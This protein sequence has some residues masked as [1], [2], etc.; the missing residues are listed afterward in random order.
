[1]NGKQDFSKPD[2][3]VD[4]T[5]H[6]KGIASILLLW[7][8][9]FGVE[10]IKDWTALLPGMDY[11]IGASGNVCIAIFLFCS[12]F[13]LY[14][15]YVGK[16]TTSNTYIFKRLVKTLIPYWVV[17]IIAIIYLAFAG[18]F[19]PKYIPV[20]LFALIH[21]DEILYVSFSW[22]IKLYVLILLVLPLIRL[23]ERKWKKN[24]L[25]DLLLYIVLP[26]AL[27]VVFARF[28]NE[29]SFINIP[30]FLIS[31]LVFLLAWFPPFAAGMLFAKYDTYKKIRSFADK[32]PNALVI[33][34]SCLIFGNMI[35]L[36]FIINGLFGDSILFRCSMVDIV[37]APLCIISC[38]LIMDNLKH[39]SRYVLPFLGK[40]SVFYWLLSGMFFLNTSELT[41]L[42]SWPRYILLIL[43]WTILLLTPFVFACDWV[44]GKLVKLILREKN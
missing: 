32:F 39:H 44:S 5:N 34:V 8:H 18:K 20:N 25:I 33:A 36:R 35:Y 7:H 29:G 28:L 38:L 9:L 37:I 21:N 6:I 24:V 19:E 30:L 15:S 16:E 3:T 12:G 11:V 1:M 23:I 42:I 41:F 17:M 10:Y 14:K 22:F 2:I 27:A 13:G 43:L 31:T 26:F 4:K 40:Q